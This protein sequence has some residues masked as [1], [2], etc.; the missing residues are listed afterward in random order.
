MRHPLF[1]LAAVAGLACAGAAP[2]QRPFI[3]TG[4]RFTTFSPTFN[5]GGFPGWGPYLSPFPSQPFNDYFSGVASLTSAQG[6]FL[7]DQQQARLLNQE[8]QARKLENRRKQAELRAYE[9]SL[10]PSPEQLREEER[11]RALRR[12]L[13]DP[14]FTEILSAD[15]LNILLRNM[16]ELASMGVGPGPTIPLDQ[17]MLRRI[18]VT[19]G[20][21]GNIGLFRDGGK[22]NWPF[23]LRDTPW[24]DDRKKMQELVDRALKQVL[25]D[26]LTPQTVRDLRDTLARME[27]TVANNG[28]T[29]PMGQLIEAQRYLDELRSAVR[30]L[31]TNN[32]GNYLTGK[33]TAQGN[34]VGELV[35]YLT[36][37]GLLFAPAVRGDE[38]AYRYL[39]EAL[40]AYNRGL[41]A[42]ARK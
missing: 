34:T 13:N 19:S 16:K 22:L 41:D 7:Q 6:Q 37:Q 20:G 28:A 27:R 31:Q 33:W 26:E 30:A 4:N 2:A 9:L 40:V 24:D 8:V 42:L 29:I 11:E 3:N 39:H 15:A 25:S 38:P 14:P 17:D 10:Q 1:L 36:Q 21:G 12:A 32:A 23:A 5:V 35:N 18:N